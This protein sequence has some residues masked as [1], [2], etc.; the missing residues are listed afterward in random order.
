M[1]G[2]KTM[3]TIR[4]YLKSDDGSIEIDVFDTQCISLPSLI[5]FQL[6]LIFH[7]WYNMAVPFIGCSKGEPRSVIIFACVSVW[8]L[9]NVRNNNKYETG[10]SYS[11]SWA[12]PMHWKPSRPVTV[13][14]VLML[15]ASC[16]WAFRPK[17]LVDVC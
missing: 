3:L 13:R 6:V 16:A 4:I 17:L 12:S 1:C 8:K 10:E 9:R 5:S 15:P 14:L 2:G 11:L 7:E